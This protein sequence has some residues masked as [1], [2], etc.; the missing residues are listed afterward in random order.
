VVVG[1]RLDRPDTLGQRCLLHT[2]SATPVQILLV[3]RALC[4]HPGSPPGDEQL[5]GPPPLAL[6]AG[7]APGGS[8]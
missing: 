5:N 7:L 2:E 3:L 6:Q 4:L 8:R 1:T